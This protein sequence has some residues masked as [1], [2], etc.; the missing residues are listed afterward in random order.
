MK[1]LISLLLVS[2]AL[3]AQPGKS[4]SGSQISG[5]VQS[6]R[7]LLGTP[8]CSSTVITNCVPEVG[9]SAPLTLPFIVGA[10]GVTQYH[11][12]KL[13]A[14]DTIIPVT[15]TEAFL[16]VAQTTGTTGQTVNVVIV[17]P[18]QLVVTGSVTDL[19]YIT[20]S[21]TDDTGADSG[22]TSIKQVSSA[23]SVGSKAMTSGSGTVLV[24]EIGAFRTG[25]SGIASP[26]TVT[27]GYLYSGTYTSG[28]S[29]TGSTGQTCNIAITNG[30]CTGSTVTVALTGSNAI[31]GSTA[32]V[33]TGAG[34]GCTSAPTT[35]TVSSGTA[36]CSGT[37]VLATTIANTISGTVSGTYFNNTAAPMTWVLPAITAYNL[38]LYACIWNDD[39]RTGAVTVVSP[40]ST[41][42]TQDGVSSGTAAGTAYSTGA[43]GDGA[44]VIAKNLTHYKFIA[45]PGAWTVRP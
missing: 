14:G 45:G 21:G 41:Y 19:H 27:T 36:T 28:I 2:S 23:T 30:A 25:E 17:G 6:A 7:T 38:G 10:T 37:P 13:A 8:P 42:F 33:V 15:G 34:T 29:A 43:L 4:I 24:F 32:L 12:V 18:T 26:G 16:G 11:Y 39:T 3:L 22:Q 35:G 5:P 20:G 31:A 40:A 9:T 44:C 1:A